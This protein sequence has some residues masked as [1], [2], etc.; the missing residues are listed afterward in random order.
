L[1]CAATWELF[2]ND[3]Q[4]WRFLGW[5]NRCRLGASADIGVIWTAREPPPIEACERWG[6]PSGIENRGAQRPNLGN[7]QPRLDQD[8][9]FGG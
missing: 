4:V 8:R 2:E 7:T 9:N 6:K 1:A 3:L 5:V